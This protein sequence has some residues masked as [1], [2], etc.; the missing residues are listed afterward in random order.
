[1]SLLS[2]I[3]ATKLNSHRTQKLCHLH[4]LCELVRIRRS[5][6][7]ATGITSMEIDEPSSKVKGKSKVEETRKMESEIFQM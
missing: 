4:H 5:G 7:S 2:I 1:M 3:V 6:D